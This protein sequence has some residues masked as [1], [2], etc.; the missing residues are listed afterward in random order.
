MRKIRF[1]AVLFFV[2]VDFWAT[3]IAAADLK[4]LRINVVEHGSN[5]PVEGAFVRCGDSVAIADSAGAARISIRQRRG[6]GSEIGISQL[7][8]V[9]NAQHSHYLLGRSRIIQVNV[10]VAE[11]EAVVELEPQIERQISFGANEAR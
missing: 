10:G 9:C 8:L 1:V 4:E 2:A 7:Q 5:T 6:D 3:D 11:Y